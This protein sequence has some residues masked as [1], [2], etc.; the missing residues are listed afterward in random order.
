MRANPPFVASGDVS[1]NSIQVHNGI[2]KA[3]MSE[4]ATAARPAGLIAKTARRVGVALTISIAVALLMM[5]NGWRGGPFLRTIIVG[6]SATTAFA[7]FE[8][9]PATHCMEMREFGRKSVETAPGC[10]VTIAGRKGHASGPL[11]L[12]ASRPELWAQIETAETPVSEWTND[13]WLRLARHIIETVKVARDISGCDRSGPGQYAG[14]ISGCESASHLFG[15]AVDG[16][17]LVRRAKCRAAVSV[18]SWNWLYNLC[19]SQSQ[20]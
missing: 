15:K 19:V 7:L 10:C 1:W 3:A 4:L 16:L 6:L 13:D 12:I 14:T 17:S 18:R 11:F 8:R 20:H 9:F 5:H 2:L